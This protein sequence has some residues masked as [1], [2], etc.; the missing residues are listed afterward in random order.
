MQK[1]YTV[2]QIEQ[3]DPLMKF[4]NYTSFMDILHQR[5]SEDH[6]DIVSTALLFIGFDNLAHINETLGFNAD[7][8]FMEKIA[9]KLRS[10]LKSEDILTKVENYQYIIMQ[11]LSGLE[12]P[13]VL[14]KD[15]IHLF[16]E[17]CIMNAQ[18]FYIHASIGISLYPCDERDVHSLI[19]IA[20]NTMKY[21][22]K[23]EKNGIEFAKNISISPFS[24]KSARIMEDFPAAIENGEIYFLYQPQYSYNKKHFV[25]AEMLARW[26]HPKYGD[27][28]PEFFIPLAE[29]SGMIDPLAVRSLIV[30]SKAFALLESN[31][32][33]D[34]SLSVNI[35]PAFLMTSSFDA[36]IHF[37]MEQYDLR[38][39]NLNF[40]ITEEVLIK[41]IDNL[42]KSLNKLKRL[43]IGIEI[44]DFGTGY[45]SL[46][47]LAYLP[48]DT[49]KVDRSFVSDI[50][51]DA[52]K[53]ALFRAIVEMSRV[54]NINVI[55]EGVENSLE[56]KVIQTFDS[57]I[58][59]GYF[60]SKPMRLDALIAKV[61]LQV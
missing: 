35:S 8:E 32:M 42:A 46:Q 43:N 16:S 18:M 59:Q 14:A 20:E 19:K 54:L 37:L 58:S 24:E 3:D 4:I 2:S 39:K 36:T 57:I 52:K 49:L 34:F 13:E 11:D 44:D 17:P 6:S 7:I 26:K 5:F 61:T 29:Q 41:N 55:A 56:D 31:G 40:E 21:T 30:A 28:S 15:I 48:I 23:N 38:G 47:H 51:K 1:S 25:G 12:N 53:R 9:K 50:D 45:T 22:Q 33:N 10:I 27:V 60:Y